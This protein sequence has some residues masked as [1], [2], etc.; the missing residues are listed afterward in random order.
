[1][2]DFISLNIQE[3][4]DFFINQ[5]D[6]EK[7]E[8]LKA[9]N[10]FITRFILLILIL[11]CLYDISINIILV[12]GLSYDKQTVK[13]D[14]ECSNSYIKNKYIGNMT[15]PHKCY[16][17]HNNGLMLSIIISDFICIF[18]CIKSLFYK[19]NFN[20][21]L[22][23]LLISCFIYS[24]IYF[25]IKND[26]SLCGLNDLNNIIIQKSDCFHIFTHCKGDLVEKCRNIYIYGMRIE[27]KNT[28]IINE[29]R[30]K[31]F[32]LMYSY[33]PIL[34]FIFYY[35]IK[36]KKIKVKKVKKESY[37]NLLFLGLNIFCYFLIYFIVVKSGTTDFYRKTWIDHFNNICNLIIYSTILMLIK[38]TKEINYFLF[39]LISGIV[40]T[41]MTINISLIQTSLQSKSIQTWSYK[42]WIIMIIILLVIIINILYNTYLAYKFKKLK[43]HL[44]VIIFNIVIYIMGYIV[45]LQREYHIHHWQ[46]MFSM[47]LI[48]IYPTKIS[49]MGFYIMNGIFINGFSQYNNEKMLF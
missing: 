1:M 23:P 17:D 42:L 25:V 37:N 28:E 8:E 43:Y 2:T 13:P 24:F 3:N 33:I 36:V 32:N 49:K 27:F 12:N 15:L 5:K 46:I 38:K 14:I 44:I 9:E 7:Q 47:M 19:T 45:S 6:S 35:L 21:Y 29:F 18:Y 20:L 26:Q 39:T 41:I 40:Y 22:F 34:I 16:I 11:I 10:K 31:L 4:P 48:N 30:D